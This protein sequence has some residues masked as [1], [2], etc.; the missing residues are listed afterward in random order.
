MWAHETAA[1]LGRDLADVAAAFWAA[2]QVIG[3][4]GPWAELEQRSAELSAD[5]EAALHATV[6]ERGGHSWPGPT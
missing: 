4:G 5:A 2:R 1:E 3:A 6:S